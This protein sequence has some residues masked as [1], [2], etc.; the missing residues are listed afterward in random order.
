MLA[1]GW[2]AVLFGVFAIVW[3]DGGGSFPFSV[4][5]FRSLR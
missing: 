4:R 1:L 2:L 3:A 5:P